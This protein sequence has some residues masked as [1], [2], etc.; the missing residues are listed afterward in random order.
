MIV[1]YAWVA[2]NFLFILWQAVRQIKLLIKRTYYRRH[3]R[4]LSDEVCQVSSKLRK[5]FSIQVLIKSSLNE[6]AEA[7]AEDSDESKYLVMGERTHTGG[8]Q[9]VIVKENT[10]HYEQRRLAALKELA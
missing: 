6:E 9:Y 10:L 5:E 1:F 4:T 8:Y 2:I 3:G 7:E